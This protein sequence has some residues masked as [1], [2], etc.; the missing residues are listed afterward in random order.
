MKSIATLGLA[1]GLSSLA[2]AGDTTPS[3]PYTAPPASSSSLYKWFAGGS[4][5]YLFDSEEEYYTL[6]F[7]MKIAENGPITHSVYLEGAYAQFSDLGLDTDIVPVTLNYKLDYNFT[8]AFSVF[9]GVGVGA[10]FVNT[11]AAFTSDDSVELAAQVFAGVGYDVTPS[12]QLY[13]AVRW[14]WVDDSKIGS[15]PVDIGDDYGLELGA[16]FKF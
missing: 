13:S 5:G 10:A 16:R 1:L 4:V 2:H 14:I 7:G 15:T 8:Q 11:D 12:F 6:H 9:G 3:A